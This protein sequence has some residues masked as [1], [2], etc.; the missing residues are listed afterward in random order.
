MPSSQSSTSRS[1][2]SDPLLI[3]AGLKVVFSRPRLVLL[4]V[5]V[6]VAVVVLATW[7]PNAKL[8]WQIA[9][10]TSIS[11]ADKLR[12]LAALAGSIGT[13]FTAFSAI[14]TIAIAALFGANVAAIA[15]L[16]LQRWRHSG[17]AGA[18]HGA[19][20]LLGLVSGILGVGCAACGTVLL[21][22]VLSLLGGVGLVALLPFGGEEFSVIGIGLLTA[23]LVLTARRIAMPTSCAI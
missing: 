2:S 7:A 12:V 21:G 23:A 20:S 17:H 9:S 5:V 8:V 6:G 11:L 14:S 13:N 18:K 15:Y 10:S 1:S 19:T 4:A 3:L 22:P 16:I